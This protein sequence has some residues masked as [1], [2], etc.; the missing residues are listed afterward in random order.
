[1]QL[2]FIF[3]TLS[4]A[5]TNIEECSLGSHWEWLSV[6]GK[7]MYYNL[8][9]KYSRRIFSFIPTHQPTGGRPLRL[10]LTATLIYLSR[11]LGSGSLENLIVELNSVL[12]PHLGRGGWSAVGTVWIHL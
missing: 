3:L 10:S 7:V 12:L 8:S 1:M 2:D 6:R 11:P 4:K 9:L 5:P